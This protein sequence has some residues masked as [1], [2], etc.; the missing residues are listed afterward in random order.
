[1]HLSAQQILEPDGVGPQGRRCPSKAWLGSG[2]GHLGIEP[3]LTC[4]LF[5]ETIVLHLGGGGGGREDV[6]GRGGGKRGWKSGGVDKQRCG[7]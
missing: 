4:G 6:R 1:M 2:Q 5:D 7:G 3:V